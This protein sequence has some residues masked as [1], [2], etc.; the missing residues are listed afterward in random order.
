MREDAL[1]E[2][3]I[4]NAGDHA[5]RSAAPTTVLDVDSEDAF[6]TLHPAHAHVFGEG[7]RIGLLAGAASPGGWSDGGAQCVVR[8]EYA[9][10]ASEVAA[11]RGAHGAACRCSVLASI[12]SYSSAGP[13][14]PSSRRR[15]FRHSWNCTS[16][17]P[18]IAVPAPRKKTR[19]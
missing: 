19:L 14:Q 1:D 10:I 8:G 12:T 17:A 18:D 2:K 7:V 11:G 9:V 5:Q 6:E 4:L 15:R 3:G 16:P 13:F